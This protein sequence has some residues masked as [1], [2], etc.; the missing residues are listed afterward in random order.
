MPYM[1]KDVSY[2]Q[3]KFYSPETFFTFDDV[4][5]VP[6]YSEVLPRD[7]NT[8][9]K[10]STNINLNIP[11]ISAAMDTV[12]QSEMAITMAQIGGLG[13]VHK[14][15]SSEEQAREIETVKRFE[16]YMVFNPITISPNAKVK[17][18]VELMK[19]H[20]ISG[21]PV[22]NENKQAIGIITNRD[23][24]FAGSMELAHDVSELMTSKDLITITKG[25]KKHEMIK[26]FH[27]HKVEKL[28]VV[29]SKGECVGLV[30]VKDIEKIQNESIATRDKEGRL[31]VAAAI[32]TGDSNVERADM[33][34]EASVDAI[35]VDT[36]HGHSRGVLEMVAKLKARYKNKVDIVGG[37]IATLEAVRALYEAGADG[38][39]VGIGPGSICTTRVV[40]GVGIPQLG[41]I[42]ACAQE[43]KKLGIAM[44]ADGGIRNSGDIAKAMAAGASCVML[45][46]LLAGT[47]ESPGD[48]V[49][50]QGRPYKQY[51][52]MGSVGAMTKGS[53]DRYF[54]GDITDQ[55]KLVPEGVEGRVPYKGNVSNVVYQ[56]IG[57]LKASMG[58]VGSSTLEEM[59]EKARFVRIT[60]TTIKENYPHDIML[61]DS[62]NI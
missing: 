46:S 51:R 56:L 47:N 16:S 59:R 19:K 22:I 52:G 11:I 48:V 3:S 13:V 43:A 44:I 58:Y 5:L 23:V 28:I 37:N 6:A 40:A 14:N 49:S 4:L 42:M 41:A 33:L 39:K 29:N 53:A 62:Q 35:I 27:K 55:N 61:M 30:T 60:S 26:L 32:G 38:V 31:V 24:R 12:T 7:V 36:A 54:Q 17:E 21:L 8:A 57:G 20:K 15:M 9:T 25:V 34:V 45:G 18:A 10:F 2:F 50:Y 1:S